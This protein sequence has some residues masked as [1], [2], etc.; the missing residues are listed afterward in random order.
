M[1]VP[2]PAPQNTG[3][4]I[5]LHLHVEILFG[6][7]AFTDPTTVENDVIFLWGKYTD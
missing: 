1:P 2:S 5:I 3:K 6:I 7:R 4:G